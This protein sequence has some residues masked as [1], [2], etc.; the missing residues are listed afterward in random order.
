MN[1]F[2]LLFGV[3]MFI[4]PVLILLKMEDLH[5]LPLR[6]SHKQR[7]LMSNMLRSGVMF[8]GIALALFLWM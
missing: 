3:V 7:N 6:F 5:D 1:A 4:T 2:L 8:V